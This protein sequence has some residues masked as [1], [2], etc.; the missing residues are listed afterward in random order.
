M[1][2]FPMKT[3]FLNCR[4]RMRK[5]RALGHGKDTVTQRLFLYT[6]SEKA[7]CRRRPREVRECVKTHSFCS[8]PLDWKERKCYDI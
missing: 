2:C 4:N 6:P 5:S 3:Q 8:H 7:D 1:E